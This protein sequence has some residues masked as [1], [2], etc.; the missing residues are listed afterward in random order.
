MMVSRREFVGGALA[1]GAFGAPRFAVAVGGARSVPPRLRFGVVSD[2]HIGG[3][4]DAE[5]QLEKALRWFRAKNVDAVLCPGDIAHSGLI[6]ELEKFAAVWHKVFGG[7]CAAD[8]RRVE[9]MIS[10]GNH[11]VD[12]WSGR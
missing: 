5:Q 9:L 4:P 3:K 8:G 7:G 1:F 12:A 10:M 11:D 6:D 2:V